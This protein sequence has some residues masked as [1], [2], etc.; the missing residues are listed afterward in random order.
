M[1]VTKVKFYKHE[2][3]KTEKG[4]LRLCAVYLDCGIQLNDIILL[5]MQT[6]ELTIS[7]PKR[8]VRSYTTDERKRYS[9]V[10]CDEKLYKMIKDAVLD[11]WQ[12][13]TNGW[14]KGKEIDIQRQEA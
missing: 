7:M 9:I 6:N 2:N 1:R 12:R 4:E 14:E 3:L 5:K 11:Q 10:H 8:S 13:Y